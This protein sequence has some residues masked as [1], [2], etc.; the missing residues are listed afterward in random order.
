MKIS[1]G[2]Q[3]RVVREEADRLMSSELYLA[4]ANRKTLSTFQ[5]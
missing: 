1:P 3:N 4:L 5:F 2:I